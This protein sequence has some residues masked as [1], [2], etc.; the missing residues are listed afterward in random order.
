MTSKKSKFQKDL[1]IKRILLSN[2]ASLG[3]VF[4]AASVI[5]VLK[6]AFPD[7]SIG[8]LVSPSMKV[9]LEEN[10]AISWIHELE[11]W[12]AKKYNSLWD[13]ILKYFIHLK[14]RN[15]L[16]LEIKTI[17]YDCAIE[18]YPFF[19][20]AISLFWKSGIPIRIGFITS[21][22]SYLLTHPIDWTK[23]EYL[24]SCYIELLKQLGITDYSQLSPF[25][26]E[27]KELVLPLQ[28]VIFHVSSSVRLKEMP[29]L[30]WRELAVLCQG[31]NHTILF[32]GKGLR[33]NQF[34]EE[35]IKDLPYCKNMC[36]FLSW[37]EL[38]TAVKQAKAVISVD[39]VV[40]HIAAACRLPLIIIYLMN[41]VID[42]WRPEYS[43]AFVFVKEE[44]KKSPYCTIKDN[45]MFFKV[46][47]PDKVYD[48]LKDFLKLTIKI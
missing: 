41:P 22:S 21:G 35:I 7:C 14:E 31:L 12:T 29:S 27:K 40:A 11:M 36:D 42:I 32:T 1:P 37:K 10:S 16:A 19:P 46:L 23:S 5:P 3:D 44:I 45:M 20:N 4:L 30:F 26:P 43:D 47:Q 2:W 25:L 24:P 9:V 34:I 18:L 38:V 17:Q 13:R 28:Y 33:E 8:F 48:K 39:S 15:K 6:Q